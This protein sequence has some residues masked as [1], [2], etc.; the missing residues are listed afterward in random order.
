MRL[1]PIYHS[2]WAQCIRWASRRRVILHNGPWDGE[3]KKRQKKIRDGVGFFF[4]IKFF[5]FMTILSSLLIHKY[6]LFLTFFEHSWLF[7]LFFS[8]ASVQR[9]L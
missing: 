2:I 9:D 1:K 5:G 7:V 4:L 3:R 8:Y 6:L